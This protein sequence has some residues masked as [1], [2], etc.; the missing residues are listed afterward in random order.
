MRN[1]MALGWFYSPSQ[2]GRYLL[3]RVPTLRPPK[4]RAKMQNPITI[5]RQLDAHQWLMFCAGFIGW[6]WDAFDFFTVS[7][8]VTEVA[9]EFGVEN[10]EVTWVSCPAYKDSPSSS[11]YSW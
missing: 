5:L 9:Q 8:T 3:S 11:S 4:Q 2:I 1:N 10:S 6:T 7:L